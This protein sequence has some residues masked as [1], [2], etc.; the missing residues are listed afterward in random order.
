MYTKTAFLLLFFTIFNK[1]V[2]SCIVVFK[3]PMLF[4]TNHWN[5]PANMSVMDPHFARCTQRKR[6]NYLCLRPQLRD[7][8]AYTTWCQCPGYWLP[9]PLHNAL[10]L[11]SDSSYDNPDSRI[12]DTTLCVSFCYVDVA[13]MYSWWRVGWSQSED[14]PDPVW[15]NWSCRVIREIADALWWRSPDMLSGW[16]SGP[17]SGPCATTKWEKNWT[18]VER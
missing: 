6:L 13:C 11:W 10:N 17:K 9:S 8:R 7:Q 1:F 3:L 14:I 16:S 12:V 2:V 4:S 5:N 15:R 18:E